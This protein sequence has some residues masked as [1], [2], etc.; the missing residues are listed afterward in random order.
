MSERLLHGGQIAV[1]DLVGLIN[2]DYLQ[3]LSDELEADK[4]VI[5]L[6]TKTV[7]NLLL[8]SLLESTYISLRSM[9][10]T[11]ETALFK[12]IEGLALEDTTAHSSIRDRLTQIDASYFEQVYEEVYRLATTYYDTSALSSYHIKR[13]DSTMLHVFGHLMEGMK[14]GN[15][16]KNKRQVK[17]TTELTNSFGVRMKFFSDQAHLS[18]ETALK[19]MIEASQ[20]S[21]KELIVFDRGLKSRAT[22]QSFSNNNVQFVT[23]LNENVRYKVEK[24]HPPL[25]FVENEQVTILSDQIVYLYQTGNQ[26]VEHPFRL[27]QIKTKED[28]ILLFLTNVFDLSAHMIAYIYRQRWEIEVFFRFMKQEM[29]LTHLISHNQNAIKVVLYTT[30]IAAMLV[31]IYKKLN[32]IKSY[33]KA[34][35]QFF[36]E[37]QANIILEVLELP[38]GVNKLKNYLNKQ[39]RRC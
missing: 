35:I 34:K 16:S 30:L 2:Q 28:K 33:K 25:P 39:V 19:E 21:K 6:K 3:R 20:H 5:K 38:N 17:L 26:L 22:L 29:N 13:Y 9:E 11:Y 27:V 7:F 14:V 37:L 36:K 32:G 1:S 15:S 23:R 24:E 18:E 12:A 4:W 31:L 10:S 8:Y